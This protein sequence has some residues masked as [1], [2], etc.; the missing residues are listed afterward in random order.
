MQMHLH[1]YNLEDTFK[2]NSN[3]RQSSDDIYSLMKQNLLLPGNYAKLSL[4]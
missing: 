1:F 4:V 3:L 2:Y